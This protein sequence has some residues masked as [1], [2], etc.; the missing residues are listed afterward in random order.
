MRVR[1]TETEMTT[2]K[3]KQT[4]QR[5]NRNRDIEIDRSSVSGWTNE[6]ETGKHTKTI[7]DTARQSNRNPVYLS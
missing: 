6:T 2:E 3:Q 4:R 7:T 5:D 1:E